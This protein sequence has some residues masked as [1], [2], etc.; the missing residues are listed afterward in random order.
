MAS[1]K[2]WPDESGCQYGAYY[3]GNHNVTD[4]SIAGIEFQ[5]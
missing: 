2:M 5:H 1:L 3:H 4:S